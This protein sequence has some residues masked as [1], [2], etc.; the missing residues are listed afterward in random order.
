MMTPQVLTG[1]GV[2]TPASWP[3]PQNPILAGRGLGE[4]VDGLYTLPQNPIVQEL[5][6][7]IALTEELQKNPVGMSCGPTSC[8][9]AVGLCGGLSGLGGGVDDLLSS[10][11]SSM[12]DWKTWA[13][14]AAGVGALIL[15]TGG[16]GSQRRS[17]IAAARAE[18]KAKVARIKA[19]RPRRYQKFV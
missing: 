6:A 19:A 17:E 13:I 2:F 18:Y 10:V 3:I 15:L 8:P 9:C 12:G 1:L 5:K 4:L 11:T 7:K 14:V 16:G